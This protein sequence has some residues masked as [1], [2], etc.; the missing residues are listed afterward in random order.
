VPAP[1]TA[2]LQ[3]LV[4]RIAERVGSKLARRGLIERDMDNAWLTAD[5]EGGPLDDLIGHSIT[6]RIAAGP[7]AGQKLFTL[8]TL[9]ASAM[10]EA[11]RQ[12]DHRGAA[13]AG[14]LSLHAGIDI[15]PHQRAS[16][17]SRR[18][19]SIHRLRRRAPTAS[20]AEPDSR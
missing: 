17:A 1:T 3:G 9:S 12:G 6:Y 5:G 4:Q 7:R 2:L 18:S 14:G 11:E 13:Q 8:Q 16:R 20:T 15:Q 19:S 10:P